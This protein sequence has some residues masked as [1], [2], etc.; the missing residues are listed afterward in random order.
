VSYEGLSDAPPVSIDGHE[1]RIAVR[2]AA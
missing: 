1:L 2:R